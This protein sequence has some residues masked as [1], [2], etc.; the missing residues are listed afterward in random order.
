MLRTMARPRP[1]PCCSLR[2]RSSDVSV[3]V[4][5][6]TA[7]FDATNQELRIARQIQMSLLPTGPLD[8]PGLTVAEEAADPGRHRQSQ[9]FERENRP[10]GTQG[11]GEDVQPDEAALARAREAVVLCDKIPAADG[12]FDRIY[13]NG[14]L[15]HVPDT[16]QGLRDCVRKLKPGAPFL[17]YLYYAFDNRP[18]WFRGVW[19]VS[20]FVRRG[21]SRMPA[22][23]RH[24]VGRNPCS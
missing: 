18:A 17:V 21:V 13:G 4:R 16:A 5:F 6:L 15:H 10:R 11:P 19:R 9:I 3:R 23:A 2:A 8:V 22:R 12:E 7:R 20:D 24:A 1:N 14:V